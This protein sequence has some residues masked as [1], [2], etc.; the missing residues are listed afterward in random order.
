MGQKITPISFRLNKNENWNSH[1]IVEKNK[2][3]NLL[4]LDLEIRKYFEKVFNFKKFKLA[5]LNILKSSKNIY[6]YVYFHKLCVKNYKTS[7]SKL[8]KILNLYYKEHNIKLFIK[9]FRVRNKKTKKKIKKMRA[10]MNSLRNSQKNYHYMNYHFKQFV[11][12]FMFMY[13]SK[14]IEIFSNFIKQ[15]LQRKKIQKKQMFHLNNNL[16]KFYRIFRDFLGYRLQFKGRL[17]KSRRKRK[18]VYQKGK[19][20]LSTLKHNIQYSFNEFKTPSGICSIKL[21]LFFKNF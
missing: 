13:F 16:E 14:N 2:Y 9:R 1:W 17:N 10:L 11:F 21:W 20:P 5:K 19:M 6:I 4:H 15:Q 7:F 3:S 18:V 8:K 12:N